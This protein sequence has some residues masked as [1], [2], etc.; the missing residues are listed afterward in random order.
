MLLAPCLWIILAQNSN[1]TD[2]QQYHSSEVVLFSDFVVKINPRDKPQERVLVITNRAIYNLLP[3]DYGKCKRRISLDA[4]E[5]ITVST[6]SDEFVLHVP[7]EYDYR[8]MSLRK[9]EVVDTLKNAFAEA[10]SSP[11]EVAEIDL[12]VLKSLCITKYQARKT[13]REPKNT[14]RFSASSM[15]SDVSVSTAGQAGENE[16]SIKRLDTSGSVT[17][18][19]KEHTDVTPD[20]FELLKVVGRGSFGKVMLVKRKGENATYAMKV[21]R[22]QAIIDRNQVEHTKAERQI[23]VETQHPFLMG[24]HYAFQTKSKL[25]LVMDYLTGM[26][27]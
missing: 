17:G 21:L 3:T 11:L 16:T 8:L 6:V 9:K 1:S 4:V 20:D 24:L 10:T 5:S 26:Y 12:I 25:Y 2:T 23:L 7:T 22:K 13:K 18:W 19:S 15:D 27:T 14:S